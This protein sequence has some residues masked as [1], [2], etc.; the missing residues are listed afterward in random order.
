[1]PDTLRPNRTAGRPASEPRVGG[2]V[3]FILGATAM[4][5]VQYSTQAILPSLSRE[6]G[7]SPA[8]AGLSVS[9]PILAL[10]V[11]AWFWGPLSDRIGRK[12]SVVTASGLLVIPSIAAALAPTYPLLLAARVAQGLCMP[13]LLTVGVSYVGDL[14]MPRI[15]ARA[16]GFYLASLVAGGLI[17]RVGVGMLAS[18]TNWR[19]ALLLVAVL[20]PAASVG[21]RRTLPDE[22]PDHAAGRALS[23][24]ALR[25]ALSNPGL[26]TVT[27]AASSLFFGFTATFSYVGFRLEAEPFLLSPGAASLLFLL[28]LFGLVGPSAGRL[29]DRVGWRRVA[30]GSLAIGGIGLG[31]SL[32]PVLPVVVLGLAILAVAGFS[33]FTAFQLGLVATARQ[34]R[35]VAS[36]LYYSVYYSVGAAGG[37]LPGLAWERWGWPGVALTVLAVFGVGA[38]VLAAGSRASRSRS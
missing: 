35:G 15:G 19:F 5:A 28:W 10:A 34:N 36:A 18:L 16:M 26:V 23:L 33:G 25:A 13:G 9:M 31:I 29:A 2:M 1:M 32:V 12:A 11:A 8:T 22:I 17:G 21:L 7:I 3:P 14:Y 27:I 6:F 38:T 37:Y 20:P 24:G 30:F 4:F